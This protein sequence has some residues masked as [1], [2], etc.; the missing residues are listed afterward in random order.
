MKD[1]VIKKEYEALK[2]SG[3][4]WE[5]FPELSGEWEVDR[6]PFTEFYESREERRAGEVAQ[7]AQ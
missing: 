6:T 2:Q 4:F 1:T 5:F 7:E 3:M